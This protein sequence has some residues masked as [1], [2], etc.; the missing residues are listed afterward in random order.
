MD[1]LPPRQTSNTPKSHHP[2]Y[3]KARQTHTNI[4]MYPGLKADGE[5]GQTDIRKYFQPLKK[6][7]ANRHGECSSP[8]TTPTPQ[9]TNC[10][11]TGATDCSSP[12]A[13]VPAESLTSTPDSRQH[14]KKAP[15]THIWA[16]THNHSSSAV[17]PKFDPLFDDEQFP[18][19][20]SPMAPRVTDLVRHSLV[21]RPLNIKTTTPSTK[22]TIRSPSETTSSPSSIEEFDTASIN[23][24]KR[25]QVP[26]FK[27]TYSSVYSYQETD[28]GPIS[29]LIALRDPSSMP[30]RPHRPVNPRSKTEPQLTEACYSDSVIYFLPQ[31]SPSSDFADDEREPLIENRYARGIEKDSTG[32]KTKTEKQTQIIEDIEPAQGDAMVEKSPK[33]SPG[34]QTSIISIFKPFC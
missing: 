20:I 24:E 19:S 29:P 28:D 22:M 10:D 13:K 25:R 26:S 15:G 23:E 11:Q 34:K 33:I 27:Q 30:L 7:D 16:R 6:P 4:D 9:R 2:P 8:A 14:G 3:Q 32:S 12:S 21:P 31:I 1:T 18:H 17:L 5:I